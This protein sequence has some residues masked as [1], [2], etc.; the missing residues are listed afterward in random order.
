M[1]ENFFFSSSFSFFFFFF[2]SFF[3]SQSTFDRWLWLVPRFPTRYDHGNDDVRASIIDFA[4]AKILCNTTMEGLKRLGRPVELACLVLRLGVE[5]QGKGWEQQREE[6]LQVDHHMRL[7]LAADPDLSTVVTIAPSEPILAEAAF[8]LSTDRGLTKI[9]PPDALLIHIRFSYLSAGDHGELIASLLVLLA[10]DAACLPNYNSL[11]VH[12]SPNTLE[13][14]KAD[15]SHRIVSVVSFLQELLGTG[16]NALLDNGVTVAP[17]GQGGIPMREAFKDAS[18][19][20]NHIIRVSDVEMIQRKYLCALIARGAAMVCAEGQSS[21]DLV[22]PIVFNNSLKPQNV[23][24]ILIRVSDN[25]G[26]GSARPTSQLFDALNPFRVGLFNEE[27]ENGD[28]RPVI[29]MVFALA[30]KKSSVSWVPPRTKGSPRGR[31]TFTAYD[32][33]CEGVS[34]STF[35]V[36]P[37]TSEGTYKSLL[38]RS[39]KLSEAYKMGE[40]D[41]TSEVSDVRCSMYSTASVKSDH[42]NKFVSG[43]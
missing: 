26:F 3:V 43:L 8:L 42:L 22:I 21:V 7:C 40:I 36:I 10:R 18:I 9:S 2:L 34:A 41:D 5:F 19:W 17:P 32:I 30:S 12:Q 31:A 29:R 37:E 1:S 28:L 24:A 6:R 27:E 4:K 35:A 33:Y 39:T 20:F 11:K 15:G 38:S 16:A 25:S 14:H 13:H 23:S